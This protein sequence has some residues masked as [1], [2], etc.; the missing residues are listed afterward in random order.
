MLHKQAT[1]AQMVFE[2]L[3]IDD[4][5]EEKYRLINRECEQLSGVKYLELEKNIGRSSIRNLLAKKAQYPTLLFLDC[6]V[7][8]TDELFLKNYLRYT[9][10]DEAVICGGHIY[11]VEYPPNNKMLHWNY[12]L[13]REVKGAQM[14]N[15]QPYHSF[16]TSN[17]TITKSLFQRVS[18][19]ESLTH[20][21]HEDTLFGL[22]LQRQ[23]VKIF[24]INN[25][26][27]H[28][29]LETNE[30][31]LQKTR[32]SLSNLLKIVPILKKDY[33]PFVKIK[34]LRTFLILRNTGLHFLIGFLFTIGKPIIEINLKSAN[35]S[36]LLLDFYKLGY[37]CQQRKTGSKKEDYTPRSASR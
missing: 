17:F 14:R 34:V 24:H 5:S 10:R 6:D 36:L 25:P 26:V 4:C 29:G 9:N 31:F 30:R 28:T 32:E 7:M 11:Q 33:L 8:I 20:Y 12:G 2:I 27:L 16:M 18:F 13:N 37:I 3:L 21:G 19:N 1:I 22:E 15:T 35:P 23:S